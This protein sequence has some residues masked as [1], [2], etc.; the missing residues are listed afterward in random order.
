M[1]APE[2]VGQQ[3]LV[4]VLSDKG[5]QGADGFACSCAEQYVIESLAGELQ[6]NSVPL[7]NQIPN[8]LIDDFDE[9]I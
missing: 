4:I 5:K 3:D 2:I 7:V 1:S 8:V 9:R 6:R